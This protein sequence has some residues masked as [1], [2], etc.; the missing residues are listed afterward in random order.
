[1]GK[2]KVAESNV[3]FLRRTEYISSLGTKRVEASSSP[4]ALLNTTKKVV[5]RSPE[6]AADSPRV[7]KRKIERSFDLA[8]EELKNH[9][10]VKH[11]SKNNVE[12]VDA[13]P[14]IPDLDAFPDSGAFVTIKFA[15]NPVSSSSE[16]DKRLLTSL[17]KPIDRTEVEEEAYEAALEAHIQDP[18]H[19]P[20]PQNFMNYEFFLPHNKATATNFRRKFDVD[21]PNRE[22]ESL[23][24]HET[25]TGGC[26]QFNRVRGYETAQET[27]LDH[28]TKYSNEILLASNDDETYPRQ[29]AVYY[30]P[31]LQKSTI[32]PQ[33]MK[34]IARTIGVADEDE[35]IVER[36][37]VTV[38]D[39]NERMLAA[40]RKYKKYPFG[41]DEEEA[42]ED[43]QREDREE[44]PL[45]EQSEDAEGEDDGAETRRARSR[46]SAE[47]R[48]AE[49]EED[50]D[51]E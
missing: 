38:Q 51:E 43:G 9:K 4:R 1:M 24:T 29:K 15:V 19:V 27:E 34:N 45:R 20:K 50:E 21:D 13:T 33:R 26:F 2:R 31:V 37:D 11:P 36:M 49:G 23:Y 28:L 41:W 48:D 47:P 42:E 8:E 30:Y 32:R 39:P 7:I 3:S 10:R 17:F 44:E 35:K 16:Y 25:D 46:S 12:L 22:D 18:V 14:L 40:M 5:R 6:P